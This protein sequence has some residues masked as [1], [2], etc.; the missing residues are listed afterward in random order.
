MKIQTPAEPEKAVFQLPEGQECNSSAKS[1]ELLVCV[2]LR[3]N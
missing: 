2:F 1:A 3:L